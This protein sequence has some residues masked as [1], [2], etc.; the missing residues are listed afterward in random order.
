M[1]AFRE[2]FSE[3]CVWG[4]LYSVAG[5]FL[6]L[7]YLLHRRA[8]VILCALAW[9]TIFYQAWGLFTIMGVEALAHHYPANNTF[10][11]N[12]M[13]IGGTLLV[14]AIAG[15]WSYRLFRKRRLRAIQP[16]ER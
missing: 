16:H 5:F 14:V 7:A 1:F 12:M 6:L 8:R 3:F 11:V 2:W 9:L 13:R 15:F 4:G 10:D